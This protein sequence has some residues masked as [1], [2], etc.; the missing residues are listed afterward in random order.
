[1]KRRRFITLA[2]ANSAFIAPA[3]KTIRQQSSGIQA[4]R[5]RLDCSDV[6][7]IDESAAV[8]ALMLSADRG[9]HIPCK[10]RD[11]PWFTLE[12]V[13][14]SLAY[15]REF[16][17]IISPGG[18]GRR[19][20]EVDRQSVIVSASGIPLIAKLVCERPRELRGEWM[21]LGVE[22]SRSYNRWSVKAGGTYTVR[23]LLSICAEGVSTHLRCSSDLHIQFNGRAS[24]KSGKMK[25]DRHP[26][27]IMK[28]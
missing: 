8:C 25:P 22:P 16:I 3:C 10:E 2:L 13:A 19:T 11:A 18:S 12:L 14:G 9:V 20:C 21:E 4:A 7:Q 24:A 5:F 6:K 27:S 28:G 1:M 17:D 15:K 26:T 23:L